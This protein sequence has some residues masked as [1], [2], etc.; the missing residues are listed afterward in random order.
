MR[1]LCVLLANLVFNKGKVFWEYQNV[2]ATA[3]LR[4]KAGVFDK[5]R[6]TK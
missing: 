1:K 2:L 3:Y 5:T 6:Y 4:K